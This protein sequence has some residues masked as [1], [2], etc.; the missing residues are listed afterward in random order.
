MRHK[1]CRR[2]RQTMGI[3]LFMLPTYM[4]ALLLPY[5]AFVSRGHF[6]VG[7]EWLLIFAILLWNVR[8]IHKL[9]DNRREERDVRKNYDI[10][11]ATR[12]NSDSADHKKRAS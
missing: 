11:G 1:L 4:A 10:G 9:L 8:Y 2:I 12:Q 6:A 5:S 7:G 3:I